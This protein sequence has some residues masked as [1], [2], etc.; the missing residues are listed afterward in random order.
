MRI[1]N[2]VTFAPKVAQDGRAMLNL[3]CGNRYHREWTNVDFHPQGPDVITYDL[4]NGIPFGDNSFDVVYHSHL[5]EHFDKEFGIIFMRECH[6]VLKHRGLIRLAVPD[7]ESI[8]RIYLKC[9]QLA[10]KGDKDAQ[11]NYD[12]II[13]ELID[14]MVRRTPG[15]GMAKYLSKPDLTNL[16]FIV[17]R[18]GRQK[19]EGRQRAQKKNNLVDVTKLKGLS[20]GRIILKARRGLAQAVLNIMLDDKERTIYEVMF[21]NSGE[22]HQWMY[23]RYSIKKLL[24]E[25]GFHD[26]EICSA[27]QSRIQGWQSFHLDVNPDGSVYKPDSLYAEGTK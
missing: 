6:R 2:D 14:Q 20:L 9:L 8:A 19:A 27:Y 15:G 3:G 21:R 12:W 25:V 4:R 17:Q 5:L 24:L 7:L 16:D 23:D 13:L 11:D 26:V 10:A 1:G 22:V 18:I